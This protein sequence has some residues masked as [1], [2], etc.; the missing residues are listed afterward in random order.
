MIYSSSFLI[1]NLIF[2]LIKCYFKYFQIKGRSFRYL[3]MHSILILKFGYI[4][5]LYNSAIH[6]DLHSGN[7][8]FYKNNEN[9]NLP[10]YQLGLIDEP[11]EKILNSMKSRDAINVTITF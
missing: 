4:S 7:I 3:L 9:S 8:F 5:V 6:C 10:K 11:L 2:G 1:D